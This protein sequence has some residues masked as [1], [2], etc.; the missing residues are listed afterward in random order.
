MRELEK[1]ARL[2]DVR[3]GDFDT[4]LQN[5]VSRI[6]AIGGDCRERQQPALLVELLRQQHWAQRVQ[7]GGSLRFKRMSAT[8]RSGNAASKAYLVEQAHN[9]ERNLLLLDFTYP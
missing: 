1:R 6:A 9:C 8:Q 4:A 7:R 2:I 3:S 5:P